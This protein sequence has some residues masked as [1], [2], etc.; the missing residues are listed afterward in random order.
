[1]IFITNVEKEMLDENVRLGAIHAIDKDVIAK[2]LLRGYATPIATLEAPGY[3]R[4]RS[5]RSRIAYDPE[6]SK[7]LLAASGYRREKP[8][9]FTIQTTRGFKPKDYE[10]IQAIVGMWRKVGIDGGHRGLRDRQA[11]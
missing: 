3:D 10:M 11:L 5:S 2:R 7:K 1:M 4:L 8:V 6:L 9:K